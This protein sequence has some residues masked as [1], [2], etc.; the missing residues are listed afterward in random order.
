MTNITEQQILKELPIRVLTTAGERATR[1]SI[2]NACP[3]KKQTL[4][5]DVC[6]KCSCSLT[7]KTLIKLAPCPLNKWE[8]DKTLLP[9]AE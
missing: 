9:K 8:L 2:C 3:E 4:G 5:I 1:I 6:D 7:L